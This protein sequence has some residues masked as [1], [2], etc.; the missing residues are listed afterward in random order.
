[1][2]NLFVIALFC[3]VLGFILGFAVAK[4]HNYVDEMTPK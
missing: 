1:V 2:T 4:F 3:G